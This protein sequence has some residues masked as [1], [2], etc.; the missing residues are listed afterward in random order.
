MATYFNNAC[1]CMSGIIKN[2]HVHIG[3]IRKSIQ[4]HFWKSLLKKSVLLFV[5]QVAGA[6]LF[7]W[8]TNN[9]CKKKKPIQSC[10]IDHAFPVPLFHSVK[11]TNNKILIKK[12]RIDKKFSHVFF[13][14]LFHFSF[15]FIFTIIFLPFFKM[16]IQFV[17]NL[18]VNVGE[19]FNDKQYSTNT[20]CDVI[21][22][23]GEEPNYK[24]FYAHS[25][26]LKLNSKYFE[27]ALSNRWIKK[28][29]D[30]FNLRRPNI[31]QSLWN[32]SQ[33]RHP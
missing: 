9:K 21:L 8:I 6:F 24:K 17:Q 4:D 12:G 15:F 30:Y 2:I 7:L 23:I 3:E 20:D 1:F 26:I 29:D 33:V 19:Y 18:F 32:N 5:V 10:F 13:L 22:H 11:P 25:V 28:D 31:P 16:V 14:F 27:S